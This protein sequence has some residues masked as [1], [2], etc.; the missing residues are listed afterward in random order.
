MLYTIDELKNH[1]K[2]ENVVATGRYLHKIAWKD[3]R[4]LRP[5]ECDHLALSLRSIFKEGKDGEDELAFDP[6]EHPFLDE[7]V[8]KYL[9]LLYF[10]NLD[11]LAPVYK[12]TGELSRD[13]LQ[14]DSDKFFELL[15]TWRIRLNDK[16]SDPLFHEVKLE[17]HRKL[18]IVRK[19]YKEGAFGYFLYQRKVLEQEIL[20]FYIYYTVKI[21]FRNLNTS[22]VELAVRQRHFIMN[23]YGYVHVVSR[24]YI[25][26]F[27]GIDPERSFNTSLPFIDPFKLP[28]SIL[29]LIADYFSRT[30]HQY[31][32]NSQYMIF[33]YKNEHYI[34][35]WKEKRMA[36]LNND[37][38][39]EIRTL[40][41]MQ[42]QQDLS[43]LQGKIQVD[44]DES[45]SFLY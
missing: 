25:P 42:S 19:Q 33:A 3:T 7:A 26:K 39:F 15:T 4:K 21:F 31:Q 17:Y 32:F 18:A 34:I 12:A 16:K 8:F 22:Y 14:R 45:L 28:T 30:P 44:V 20:A 24:H 36:E 38:G 1:D 10:E 35:W 37:C 29:Q 13:E 5:H 27:N 11:F 9:I 6:Y 41:R 2:D 23:Y 43:K 40:Y